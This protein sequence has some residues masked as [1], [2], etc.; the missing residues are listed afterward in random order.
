MVQKKSVDES[1]DKLVWLQALRAVAALLVV[2]THSIYTLV[3]KSG[4]PDQYIERFSFTGTWGVAIFF[5]ISGFI[6]IHISKDLFTKDGASS[7]F[8]LR[9]ILRIVP[10]Y[11]IATFIYTAKLTV[12]GDFPG[13]QDLLLSLLFIPFFDDTGLIRPVYGLGWTLNYEMYFYL[14]ISFSLIF[15]RNF[16]LVFVFL[17]IGAPVL[18]FPILGLQNAGPFAYFVSRPII[19]MF[20]LGI[21]ARVLVFDLLSSW[22]IRR[23]SGSESYS[24]IAIALG[25]ASYSIYLTHS[26]VLGPLAR[27]WDLILP[28]AP[29]VYFVGVAI[30]ICIAVG[31]LVH[32]CVEAPLLNWL[33]GKLPGRRAFA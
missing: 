15:T 17:L 20:L 27:V 24:R 14:I 10:L 30:L 25:D 3:E 1:R 7:K 13:G 4:L 11:W 22:R 6:M 21:A 31:Y 19:L 33:G 32:R 12:E 2:F 16:A 18:L 9:R 5:A 29:W 26:F 28:G 23:Y 8:L